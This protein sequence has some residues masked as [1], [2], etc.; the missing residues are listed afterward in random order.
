MLKTALFDCTINEKRCSFDGGGAFALFFRPYPWGF[1][2][3]RVPTP[4][5]L[6]SKAKKIKMKCPGV[7]RG[8]GGGASRSWN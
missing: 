5:Y 2:T 4:G 7:S 8:G 6:P 1:D 3:S